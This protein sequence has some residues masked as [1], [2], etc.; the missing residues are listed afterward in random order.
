MI[1]SP[2]L[3]RLFGLSLTALLALATANAEAAP[4][5][6]AKPVKEP[7]ALGPP[8]PVVVPPERMCRRAIE[9]AEHEHRLP[10]GLLHAIG[11]VESGRG[12]G[13]WPWTINAEGKGKFFATKE[14]AVAEVRALQERGVRIIDVGC[15]QVNLY[16]HPQAF[17]DL[18]AAF[19]PV[20]NARYAGLFLTRLYAKAGDWIT[21]TGYYHSA[22]PEHSEPYKAN[23]LARWT[24][25]PQGDASPPRGFAAV[26]TGGGGGVGSAFAA[27]SG[28]PVPPEERRRQTL[29]AAWNGSGQLLDQ[30]VM[31]WNGV[32]MVLMQPPRPGAAPGTPTR[33]TFEITPFPP[34]PGQGHALLQRS[35][36]TNAA[37][38]SGRRALRLEMAEA[39][40]N[41][42]LLPQSFSTV[43][44]VPRPAVK[45]P[46]PKLR[47]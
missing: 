39:L 37:P 36:R 23:V 9:I 46:A 31:R 5:Q 45:V 6:K 38:G 22:N 29:V 13:S 32:Q 11:R 35:A 4:K 30:R 1:A 21:A 28:R 41:A 14:E 16:H 43:T 47:Q 8:Q 10:Q 19:E 3:R 40:P 7:E 42:S 15:M 24:G 18:D 20:V 27:Q 44:T 12:G 25:A 2:R 17:P 34:P 33:L 26:A